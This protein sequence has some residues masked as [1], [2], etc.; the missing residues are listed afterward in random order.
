MIP[1]IILIILYIALPILVFYNIIPVKLRWGVFIAG[2]LYSLF[3][4]WNAGFS[5]HD[6]GFRF[7]NFQQ[8]DGYY[9]I[10]FFL[11]FGLSAYFKQNNYKMG[12]ISQLKGTLDNYWGLWFV[13]AQEFIF[14]SIMFPVL[15][16][17]N[18]P[19]IIII[20]LMS[21]IFGFAH[22]PFHSWKIFWLT[23]GLGVGLT[24]IYVFFPNFYLVTILHSIIWVTAHYFKII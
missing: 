23:L 24:S 3:V 9:Y 5:L 19:L 1:E 16:S 8:A 13:P 20:P 2:V 11:A 4:A 18:L 6:L 14:R 15:L 7:D 17:F 10:F 22:I 12:H 21:F